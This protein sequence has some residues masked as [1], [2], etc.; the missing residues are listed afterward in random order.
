MEMFL[1]LVSSISLLGLLT[2][3]AMLE[4][5]NIKR[6]KSAKDDSSKG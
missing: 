4:I 1:M 3:T 2:L 6:N 5:E